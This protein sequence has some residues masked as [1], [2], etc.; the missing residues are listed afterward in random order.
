MVRVILQGKKEREFPCNRVNKWI[1]FKKQLL[2]GSHRSCVI[3]SNTW[4]DRNSQTEIVFT[5][6]LAW[7]YKYDIFSIFSSTSLTLSLINC[8]NYYYGRSH[9]IQS[10]TFLFSLR[11]NLRLV[12]LDQRNPWAKL[13]ESRFYSEKLKSVRHVRFLLC[14]LF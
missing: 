9:L 7:H 13:L 8:S 11:L 3:C 5:C 14:W 2:I 4:N 1:K 10:D 6:H 12:Y